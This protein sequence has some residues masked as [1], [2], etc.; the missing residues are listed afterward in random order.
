MLKNG[1]LGQIDIQVYPITSFTA[2]KTYNVNINFLAFFSWFSPM[3]RESFR[4]YFINLYST[5]FE[6]KNVQSLV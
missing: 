4:F 5:L 6:L 2:V 3:R 1:I